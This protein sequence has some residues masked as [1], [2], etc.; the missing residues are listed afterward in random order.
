M[1]NLLINALMAS[2]CAV[3]LVA[4]HLGCKTSSGRDMTAQFNL[5]FTVWTVVLFLEIINAHLIIVYS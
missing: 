2:L 4:E 5:A 1:F 3:Q